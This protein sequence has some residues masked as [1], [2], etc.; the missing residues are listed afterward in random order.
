MIITFVRLATTG[1]A[2]RTQ[3]VI[4]RDQSDAKAAASYKY[5]PVLVAVTVARPESAFL[6][7]T[8]VRM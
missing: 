2:R 3:T 5:W 1:V 4:N 8:R 7:V 6:P